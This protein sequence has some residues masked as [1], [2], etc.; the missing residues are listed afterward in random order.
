M[1]IGREGLTANELADHHTCRLGKWYDSVTEDKYKNNTFVKQLVEPHEKAHKHGIQ[2]INYYND[3][4]F[5]DAFEE[6]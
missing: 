2:A 3:K 1:I 4:N 5:E 6:I